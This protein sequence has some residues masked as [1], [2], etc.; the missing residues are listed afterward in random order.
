M[1]ESEDDIGKNIQNP[2]EANLDMI[3]KE[4]G[5][6]KTQDISTEMILST[7]TTADSEADRGKKSH[8]YQ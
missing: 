4:A 5:A 1:T 3:M 7:G 2:I 6:R 8:Q